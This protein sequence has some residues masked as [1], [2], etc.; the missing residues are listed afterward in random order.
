MF[1]IPTKTFAAL[2]LCVQALTAGP[3]AMEK[4]EVD[5][6]GRLVVDNLVL[7]TIG[8]PEEA[9]ETKA[10][11]P[12]RWQD[13]WVQYD[14]DAAS[15]PDI[16]AP[17]AEI[18][19]YIGKVKH[20][21][22]LGRLNE[23][24]LAPQFTYKGELIKRLAA[25]MEPGATLFMEHHLACSR[26]GD[27]HNSG[28]H[29]DKFFSPYGRSDS[30]GVDSAENL[31]WFKYSLFHF[32]NAVKQGSQFDAFDGRT[33]VLRC[34]EQHIRRD[35]DIWRQDR[36][37]A[38]LGAAPPANKAARKAVNQRIRDLAVFNLNRFFDHKS[39]PQ[40]DDLAQL[41]YG[42]RN[43]KEIQEFVA[44]AGF[45]KPFLLEFQ[46]NPVDGRVLMRMLMATRA[47]D[48]KAAGKPESEDKKAEAKTTAEADGNP[49]G[50][51]KA[52][53]GNQEEAA[54]ASSI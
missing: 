50:K 7:G 5:G 32:Q 33:W 29:L 43:A 1:R 9:P 17:Y 25:V 53:S 54:T 10:G 15:E 35:A 27:D 47:D 2:G 41:F 37:L 28:G 3:A 18:G 52:G 31:F 39:L 24:S 20:A 40:L 13:A 14:Q 22:F 42:S 34:L 30:N 23:G 11:E 51:A 48:G 4:A 38:T 26:V 6:N 19:N 8:D 44:E 36:L 46:G 12:G 16:T 21:V 49:S 45:P